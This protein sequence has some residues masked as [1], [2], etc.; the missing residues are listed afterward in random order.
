MAVFKGPLASTCI[1]CGSKVATAPQELKKV[2][3][4]AVEAFV[5]RISFADLLYMYTIK[6][7]RQRHTPRAVSERTGWDLN[8]RCSTN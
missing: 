3:V 5:S 7:A 8:P 4:S 2:F 1:F 6:K